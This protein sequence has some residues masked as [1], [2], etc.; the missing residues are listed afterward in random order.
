MI[1]DNICLGAKWQFGIDKRKVELS[2][3]IR[4]NVINKKVANLKS[5]LD[6]ADN[7]RQ[8]YTSLYEKAWEELQ[9]SVVVGDVIQTGNLGTEVY[10]VVAKD[11]NRIVLV[12]ENETIIYQ[13]NK[14][15]AI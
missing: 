12:R 5:V 11:D 10:S 4:S 13:T 8:Y 15:Y 2:A 1:P 14:S 9:K 6:D 3:L 7:K